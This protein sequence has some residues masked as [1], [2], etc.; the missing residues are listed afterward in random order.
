MADSYRSELLHYKQITVNLRAVSSSRSAEAV[1]GAAG[2]SLGC[3]ATGSWLRPVTRTRKTRVVKATG[4][5]HCRTP[6]LHGMRTWRVRVSTLGVPVSSNGC[7]LPYGC[8]AQGLGLHGSRHL[9]SQHST[10][11]TISCSVSRS[12]TFLLAVCS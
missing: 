4:V 7:G 10:R 6:L 2:S 12:T 5:Q 3:R 9:P 1:S 8:Q 11:A